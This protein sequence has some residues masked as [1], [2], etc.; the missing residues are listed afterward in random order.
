M[1]APYARDVWEGAKPLVPVGL[2][3]RFVGDFA[4]L[5]PGCQ[6]WSKERRHDNDDPIG[7]VLVAIG[8]RLNDDG[9][10]LRSFTC[11]DPYRTRPRITVHV[12][13]DTEV[14]RDALGP[15]DFARVRGLWRRLAEEIAG[16]KGMAKPFEY[17][18]DRWQHVLMGVLAA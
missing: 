16:G 17:E 9:E 3:P 7:G 6:V 8:E 15:V 1:S 2:G 12:L 5:T 4:E 14:N 11:L 18:L 13:T 10:L